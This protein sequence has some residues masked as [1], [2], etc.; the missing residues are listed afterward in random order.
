MRLEKFILDI[1]NS[2]TKINLIHLITIILFNISILTIATKIV[3]AKMLPN[4]DSD[5][6]SIYIYVKDVSR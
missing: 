5:I 1:L 3:K 6:F 4:K 2:K